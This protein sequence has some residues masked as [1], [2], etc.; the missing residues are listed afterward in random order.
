MVT[1]H[2]YIHFRIVKCTKHITPPKWDSPLISQ[3][4]QIKSTQNPI[5]AQHNVY[6]YMIRDQHRHTWFLKIS[7]KE[8]HN[9]QTHARNK[10]NTCKGQVTLNVNMILN[11][12]YRKEEHWIW[13][14]TIYSKWLGLRD[15]INERS[16]NSSWCSQVANALQQHLLIKFK[17]V[18]PQP[19]WVLKG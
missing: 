12:S 16:L 13:D 5:E 11:T 18:G 8:A 1:P 6:S 3:K 10:T 9:I 19:S 15:I 2:I 14:R 17:L 4:S 7:R